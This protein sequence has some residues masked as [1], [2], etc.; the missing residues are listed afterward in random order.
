M[1]EV[2]F[3]LPSVAQTRLCLSPLIAVSLSYVMLFCYFFVCLL[4]ICTSCYLEDIL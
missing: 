1:R 3:W 4:F 2:Q